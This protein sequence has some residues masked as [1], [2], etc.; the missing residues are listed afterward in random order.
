MMDF[1]TQHCLFKNIQN[2][3]GQPIDVAKRK[4]LNQYDEEQKIFFWGI[5]LLSTDELIGF[6]SLQLMED[7]MSYEM[8]FQLFNQSIENELI[9]E[10]LNEM[11]GYAFDGMKT[12]CVKTKVSSLNVEM[13]QLLH[14]VGMKL[15]EKI[16]NQGEVISVYSIKNTRLFESSKMRHTV[17]LRSQVLEFVKKECPIRALAQTGLRLDRHA[18]ID[19]MRDYHFNL[20]VVDEE[21]ETYQKNT[22]WIQLF[23]EIVI[24]KLTL[25]DEKAYLFQVQYQDG[26]RLDFQFVCLSHYLKTIYSDSLMKILLDK[27]G[28]KPPLDEPSERTHYIQ[29]PTVEEFEVLLND[30][31]WYQ[32]EVA[33]AIYRDELPLAKGVYDGVLMTL[34]ITLLSWKI[35]LRYDWKV[36]IG[37]RGRWLK[38]YLSESLYSDFI[39]LYPTKGYISLWERLFCMGPFINKIASELSR[40]LGFP[41][42][43]KQGQLV[44]KFVHRINSLPDNATDFNI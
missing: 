24:T 14:E 18:P 25:L 36:D 28:V 7:Y 35:G 26:V 9:I 16:S 13:I 11:I 39:H 44:T 32:I 23:G 15:E 22:E 5:R 43:E 4:T 20:F 30:V 34:I 2:H 1:Q 12:P 41:Y 27:D 6:I 31:W 29:K 17:T 10:I 40:E 19:L 37:R 8:L 21:I 38:R 3:S 33:K 42:S